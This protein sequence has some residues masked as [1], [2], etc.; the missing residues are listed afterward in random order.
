[1]FLYQIRG[2]EVK[3]EYRDHLEK[4]V[5]RENLEILDLMADQAL[6]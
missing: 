5:K 4:K 6:K 2:S 3:L 1:M